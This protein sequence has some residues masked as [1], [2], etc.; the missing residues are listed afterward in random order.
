MSINGG[1][2]Q[3]DCGGLNLLS[4]S[5][6]TI[7]GIFARS[8]AAVESG[9]PVIACNCVY[10][11]GVPMTPTP[12]FGIEEGGAYIFTAS[13]LQVVVEDDDGVTIR[14]LIS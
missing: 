13:I 10:G 9:K 11:T 12:V 14:S 6:Q 5:E 8:K 1:Y 7:S 4:E 2:V 3:V